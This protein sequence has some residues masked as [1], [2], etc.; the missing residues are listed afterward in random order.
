MD[1]DSMRADYRVVRKWW[2][3]SE[4]WTEAELQE[5]DAGVKAAVDG[6][7]EALVRCWAGWLASLANEIREASKRVRVMEAAMRE[8]KAA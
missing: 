7:D 4:G 2:R 6:C 3:E 5:A 8:R 1:L